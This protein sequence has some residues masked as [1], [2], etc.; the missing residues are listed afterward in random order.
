MQTP[1]EPAQRSASFTELPLG[2]SH[3]VL[4]AW[5]VF[6]PEENIR[7]PTGLNQAHT[8][9]SQS[10]AC[11]GLTRTR[12]LLGARR[13]C[14]SF[15]CWTDRE[16]QPLTGERPG[17]PLSPH[18]CT[19][20]GWSWNFSWPGLCPC[21]WV[22]LCVPTH[23]QRGAGKTR[24]QGDEGGWDPGGHWMVISKMSLPAKPKR[25]VTDTVYPRDDQSLQLELSFLE[26][27]SQ[28]KWNSVLSVLGALM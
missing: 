26:A 21:S 4:C 28:N 3:K 15:C 7:A 20:R 9:P 18:C 10:W 16:Q 17:S 5:R 8:P 23:R 19:Q 22:A 13:G 14:L 2:S 1:Q 24:A 11:A 12:R 6:K 25:N 27:L